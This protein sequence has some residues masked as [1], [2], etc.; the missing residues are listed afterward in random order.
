MK[1]GDRYKILVVDDSPQDVRVMLDGLS[2]TYDAFF[3]MDGPEALR[4]AER[5]YPDLTL[6][7]IYM[8]G[9]D[10]FEVC[11]RLKRIPEIAENPVIFITG[12]S[13]EADHVKGLEMGAVDFITKPINTTVLKH[14]VALHLRLVSAIKDG[15]IEIEARKRAEEMLQKR[16]RR[17]RMLAENINDVIWTVDENLNYTYLSPSAFN[18]LGYTSE[19]LLG[20]P[21]N[22]LLTPDSQ[23]YVQ[24]ATAKTMERLTQT[25]GQPFDLP[26]ME[27]EM[28]HK[29]GQQ[30]WVEV[31]NSFLTDQNDITNGMVGVARD[32]SERK[33]A[34]RK[35]VESEKK[36]RNLFENG[37][38]LI[39]LHDLEGKLLETNLPYKEEYDWQK[40]DIEGLNIREMIPERHRSRFDEYLLRILKNGADEGYLK[41]LTKSG[42]E[43]IL[44]YRNK[45]I[46][47]KNGKP[48]AVQGAARD[49]TQRIKSEKSL[50]ES[51][52]KY[53]T[54]V[55]Q[56]V[57]GV[58]VLQD[59]RI[60]FTN[61]AFAKISGYGI[62]ELYS[63][64]PEKVV[65][66]THP[67]DQDLVWERL[68][69]RLARKKVPQQYEFRSLRKDGS[70]RFLEMFAN[71]IT[72]NGNPAIQGTIVD[73]TERK[74]AEMAL[75]ISI[76]NYRQL[77]N[78]E[79]DAILI[80]DSKTQRIVDVNPAALN[81]YGYSY[82]EI[83]GLQ[84]MDL[85]AEPR[86]SAK[87]IKQI[88]SDESPN[89]YRTV[90]QR[91]HKS[92]DGK[93]IPVEIAHGFY[94]RDGRKMIC[95]IIRDI[96]ERERIKDELSAEKE[97]LTVTLRSIGDGVIST[98]L[99]GKIISLN[100]VAEE[101][102][103]WKE[104]EA[105]GQPLTDVFNIV[106]EFD[107]NRCEDPVGKVLQTGGII[108]LSNNT[109]L[110][111]KDGKEYVIADS[112]APIK[113]S[114]NKI[115]G[116]VLVFRD[117]TE[118]RK[119]E[120]ELVKIQKLESLGVLAG[121]IAH[122]FN[123][124]LTAIIGNLS[125]A[126]LDSKPG[127]RVV[128]LLNEMEKASLQAKNLTQ[129]LLTFSK[130]GEPVKKLVNLVELIKNSAS[131]S[132][133]GSN[134]RCDFSIPEDMLP[135]EVDEGQIGQVIDNLIINAD[136][137]MPEGGII[138]ICADRVALTEDNEFSLPAGPYLRTSF[139]DQGVGIRPDHIS[140]VFD[141]Y[142]TTKQRG[143]GLGLTVAYSIV[144]K[145]NGRLTVESELG[146][147]TTFSIYLPASEKT[148]S[149]PAD[150]E[151]RLFIGEGKI[152][153]MDDEEFI[154]ELAIQMLSKI[155]YKVWVAADGK[156]AIEIYKQARKEGKPFDIVIMDLTIPGGMGGKEAIKKFKILDPNVK[157]LVS[158]GY[159]NDPIMS[160]FRDYGFEGVVKKPYR[161][162]DMSDALRTVL[163][164]KTG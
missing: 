38:D 23:S 74:R 69:K 17:Y 111:S 126:K 108:G 124:F 128:V 78:A 112:G 158:S 21:L 70:E 63:M 148:K 110:I 57:Q 46:L 116:A 104:D 26:L 32:I 84:A 61:E 82:E 51:E 3:A 75:K 150:E 81:L 37:S 113:D 85:S 93:K 10:G 141:P 8:G 16:E 62:D 11:R 58:I 143:S 92:K 6:L 53:K 155:G 28:V 160:N 131:F 22:M 86:K 118:K 129:Q 157:A 14:R 44:E 67:E 105:S 151:K 60:V 77:F 140:K 153:V 115:L 43:V 154:R 41:G 107:R 137:A 127:D 24:E 134:V 149:Q 5:E 66:L 95:A 163:K 96:S 130:G 72:Y 13:E 120:A 89:G 64:S 40:H 18:L 52:E 36:Y 117:I 79:P 125:L 147:G 33:E 123:N 80:V 35:V 71:R 4:I 152:L 156:E 88:L 55:E 54:L 1:P 7:D 164:E 101:L 90:V 99:E 47:D 9:I 142:F 146:H 25:G 103:G 159:S 27:Y 73:I 50:K 119:M 48:Q 97:R 45:L 139:R 19:E 65:A 106:D 42:K 121:G 91:F 94:I 12:S 102:T 161:I 114:Q 56:S 20:R 83:C 59:N 76:S 109:V 31:R 132:L 29:S 136:H 135:V 145:H 34:Q 87:H 2:Q 122:D 138:E 133:R 39:C 162:Q 98:D 49:V 30:I 15:L 100:K 68:Q 144:D